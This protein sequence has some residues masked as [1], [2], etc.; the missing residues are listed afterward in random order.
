MQPS[1]APDFAEALEEFEQGRWADAARRFETILAAQPL[2]GPAAFYRKYC[3]Q[4]L[5]GTSVP[6]ARG[7]I[8]LESK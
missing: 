3:D 1:A 5:D 7:A 2:D 8:R 4:Y 6:T